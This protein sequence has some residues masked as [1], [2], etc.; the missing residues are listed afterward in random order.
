MFH[1]LRL[2][3]VKQNRFVDIRK[4]QNVTVA[5]VLLCYRYWWFKPI[6]QKIKIPPPPDLHCYTQ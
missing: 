6:F 4:Q 1:Y 3:V 5:S 2:E